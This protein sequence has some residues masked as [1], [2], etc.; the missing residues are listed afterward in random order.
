[1][2]LSYPAATRSIIIITM[3]INIWTDNNISPDD[4]DDD[5]SARPWNNNKK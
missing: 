3:F 4:G 1:M 2:R 5:S